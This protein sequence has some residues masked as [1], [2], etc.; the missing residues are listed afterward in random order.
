[1]VF[2]ITVLRALAACLITN[3]HYVGV[4]PTDIVANGGLLGDVIFFAVSGFCLYNIRLSFPRWYAKRVARCYTPVWLI[5]AV[6]MAL[7][8]YSLNNGISPAERFIYPTSYHFIA[9]IILL[10]IPYYLIIKTE[11]L[12]THLPAVMLAVF[13]LYM[14]V[15]VFA[16]DKTVYEIDNVH[17]PMIR[18]LFMESML[19]GAYFRQNDSVYRK[20]KT[21]LPAVMSGALFCLYFACKFMLSRYAALSRLQ[22]VC[23]IILFVLLYFVLRLFASLDA[24]LTRLPQFMKTVITFLSEITLEIYLVQIVIID[25]LAKAAAFPINWILLTTTILS[26]ATVLHYAVK[27]IYALADFIK[28]SVIK[29]KK[30]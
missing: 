22:F 25:R 24:K 17:K 14:A 6:Y 3:S 7:G 28:K 27:G 12:K 26:A 11:A 29:N 8:A 16:Y 13:V 23:Q 18:F 2:F 19:L 1:M 15:Y 5:T 30:V 21:A 9:S 20:S 4:Y 10:Y